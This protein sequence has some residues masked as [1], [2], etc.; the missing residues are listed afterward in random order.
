MLEGLL[1]VAKPYTEDN[2]NTHLEW[3]IEEFGMDKEPHNTEAMKVF[4]KME[5]C[6]RHFKRM[7]LGRGYEVVRCTDDD[8]VPEGQ[9]EFCLN[10]TGNVPAGTDMHKFDVYKDAIWFACEATLVRWGEE[11]AAYYSENTAKDSP[12]PNKELIKKTCREAAECHKIKRGK[13][14]TK[15]QKTDDASGKTDAELNEE[16]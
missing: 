9:P 13:G 7:A 11:I 5:G 12:G 14:G 10:H 16:L 4:M 2:I 6:N 3:K 15:N 8:E 1:E